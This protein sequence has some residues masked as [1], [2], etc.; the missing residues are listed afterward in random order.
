MVKPD[1]VAKRWNSWENDES[2]EEDVVINSETDKMP[3]AIQPLIG[4]KAKAHQQQL[5]PVGQPPFQEMFMMREDPSAELI[6]T[7]AK[8]Q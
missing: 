2:K 4:R 1:W 3:G 6:D 5:Q 7:A 8:F